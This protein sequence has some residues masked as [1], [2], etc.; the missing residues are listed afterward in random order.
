MNATCLIFGFLFV[1][2]GSVFA[3]GRGH[4]H[5]AAWKSMTDSEKAGIRIQSLCRNIG[6]MFALCGLIFL[7]S[8][9]WDT[10]K[11]KAFIWCMVAWLILAGMDVYYI[12][13]SGRYKIE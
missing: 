6:C 11:D 12:E 4:I 13:R 5:L 10:F 8:G 9:V 7:T 2:A 3:A 1:V